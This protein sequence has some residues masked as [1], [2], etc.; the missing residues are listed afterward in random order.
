M[1]E[2]DLTPE[3]Y[4]AVEKWINQQPD[5]WWHGFGEGIVNSGAFKIGSEPLVIHGVN[6]ENVLL[7]VR[8]RII[9][10]E[11]H[12][13]ALEQAGVIGFSPE[14]QPGAKTP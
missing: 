12:A 1:P 8:Y 5:R 7:G 2:K 13:E 9:C 14:P 11:K 6:D 10:S 3:E 4:K